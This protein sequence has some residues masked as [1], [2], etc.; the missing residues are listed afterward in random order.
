MS[1]LKVKDWAKAELDSTSAINIDPTHWKSYHRRSIARS[2][3]G[4]IRASLK[5][6]QTAKLVLTGNAAN[7]GKKICPSTT[8]A[9]IKKIDLD[10]V[11]TRSSLLEAVRKAPKKPIPIQVIKKE[12]ATEHCSPIPA[13]P[14]MSSHDKPDDKVPAPEPSAKSRKDIRKSITKMRTWLEFEQTWHS[15]VGMDKQTCLE[16]LRP[17]TLTKIY[18]NG[19]EDSDLLVDLISICVEIDASHSVKILRA[20][21]NIPSVDMTVMMM[22]T[23]DKKIVSQGIEKITNPVTIT[24]TLKK[25]GIRSTG[26]G[27]GTV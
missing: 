5:D 18:G 19:M 25:F 23:S 12:L 22:N 17:Q 16:C 10:I 7:D 11:K 27:V 6:L 24:D 21:S 2:S 13:P 9:S 20:L 8:T 26:T 3:L 1:Y 14:S 15:L 4:K